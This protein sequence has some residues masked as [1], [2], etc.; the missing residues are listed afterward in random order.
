MEYHAIL[1][2]VVGLYLRV[3]PHL[4]VCLDKAISIAHEFKSKTK[5]LLL[6]GDHERL[7]ELAKQLNMIWKTCYRPLFS[8]S[9]LV[10]YGHKLRKEIEPNAIMHQARDKAAMKRAVLDV[11]GFISRLPT[12]NLAPDIR[13]DFKIAYDLVMVEEQPVSK[14]E[15]LTLN[16]EDLL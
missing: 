13:N 5:G 6:K 15:K 12:P 14:P 8:L 11:E 7:E 9:D 16:T 1:V 2:S 10:K 3:L 4:I